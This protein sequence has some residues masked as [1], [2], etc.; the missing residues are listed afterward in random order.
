M[1]SSTITKATGKT[2]RVIPL[3]RRNYLTGL[4]GVAETVSTPNGYTQTALALEYTLRTGVPAVPRPPLRLITTAQDPPTVNLRD[5]AEDDAYFE[6]QRTADS[7]LP[8]PTRWTARLTQAIVE[9][10]LG[11]RP[12]HQ[13]ARWMSSDVYAA[14]VAE[15]TNPAYTNT[16]STANR[17]HP[18]V[19]FPAKSGVGHI[20]RSVH[21]GRP[22]DGVVE[23]NAVVSGATRSRAIALRLEGWDGRWLCTSLSVI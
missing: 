1:N 9:V 6:R 20:V 3:A 22:T 4:A 13:L 5:D 2:A 19:A 14:M 15:A 23:A 12:L 21:V 18:S 8:D 11:R 10:W 17:S 16:E 7:E